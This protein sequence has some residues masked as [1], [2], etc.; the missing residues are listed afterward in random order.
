PTAPG[1]RALAELL[2]RSSTALKWA[3]A[4]FIQIKE[5]GPTSLKQQ[6]A[7]ERSQSIPHS[8][9]GLTP[10]PFCF[11]KCDYFCCRKPVSRPG[12][13]AHAC[14]PSTWEAEIY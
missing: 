4:S 9:S 13:V 5:G 2:A 8:S 3:V 7:E 6:L 11:R 14:N 12:A 1:R 10:K